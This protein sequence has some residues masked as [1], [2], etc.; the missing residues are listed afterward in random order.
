MRYIIIGAGAVGAG[1]GGRLYESGHDV[2][3]VA[4]GPHLAALRADGLRFS[5]P[6]GTRTLAVPAV[7]GPEELELGPQDVLVLAV[8]AQHTAS[9]LEPWPSRP[10]VGEDGTAGELLPLVCAQNGVVNERAAMRWFRRVYGMSVWMPATYLEPGAVAVPAAPF[11]GILNLAA[12]RV[13]PMRPSVR[14]LRTWSA[15][16]SGRRSVRT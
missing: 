6:E 10:V 5:T 11:S 1:I 13:A 2:A 9:A 4:R 16:G 12:T 7:G 14:S 3:L 8:K 15:R